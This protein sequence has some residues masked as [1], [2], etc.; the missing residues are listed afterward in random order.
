MLLS[1]AWSRAQSAGP[2]LVLVEGISGIGKTRLAAQFA[3][4]L[5]QG[6]ATVLYGRSDED[7]GAPYQPWIDILDQY[8]G[9]A[10]T[11]IVERHVQTFGPVLARLV[12]ALGQDPASL[13]A[14]Q[15]TDPEAERYMLFGAVSHLLCD[16]ADDRPLLLVLDDLHWADKA[17]L[18]LV[19]HLVG[20]GTAMR[21]LVVGVSWGG[22]RRS[23]RDP[24]GPV[25]R[26]RR[27]AAGARR[28]RR[29]RT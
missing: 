15:T 28:I 25:A 16:A 14:R 20:S 4:G 11:A 3:D 2:G 9:T 13:I 18:L 26:A 24:Q 17:T 5:R 27:T 19:R 29:Q 21:M 1:D 7:L 6:G 23:R 22:V 12:P 10:R 8:V